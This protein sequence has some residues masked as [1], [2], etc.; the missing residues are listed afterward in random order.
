MAPAGTDKV[1]AALG[2]S[3]LPQAPCAHACGRRQGVA[4]PPSQTTATLLPSMLRRCATSGSIS[5]HTTSLTSPRRWMQAEIPI[6]SPQRTWVVASG[7][8]AGSARRTHCHSRAGRNN[9][10]EQRQTRSTRRQSSLLLTT[11]RCR[12]SRQSQLWTRSAQ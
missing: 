5:W 9:A 3:D 10:G 7:A 11:T 6:S 8:T 4:T 2:R 1:P 12:M